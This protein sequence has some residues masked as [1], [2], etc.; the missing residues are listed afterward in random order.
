MPPS[1]TR[2]RHVSYVPQLVHGQLT[3]G[4]LFG[5]G[6]TKYLSRPSFRRVQITNGD[7]GKIIQM[8]V[9][10]RQTETLVPAEAAMAAT[11]PSDRSSSSSS[12]IGAAVGRD[13]AGALVGVA[14]GKTVGRT[15]GSSVGAAVGEIWHADPE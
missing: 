5:S 9:K 15:V 1:H 6:R 4:T 8:I 14:V 2:S 3:V 7:F 10:M 12:G 13:V 11:S